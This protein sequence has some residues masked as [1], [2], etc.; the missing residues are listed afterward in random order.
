VISE[1]KEA[2]VMRS[3]LVRSALIA[4]LSATAAFGQ[5]RIIQTNSGG[6]NVHLIDPAT[7][8]VVGEIKGL[9]ANHGAIG[10]PD[11]KRLYISVEGN[12]TL[13]V[14]DAKTLQITKSIPL[15]GRPNNLAV[16]NDG[17]KVYV[18]IAA[19]P[20]A[21]EVIDTATLTSVKTIPT[22]GAEHNVYV[23]PDGKYLAAGSVGGK[24]LTV[25][26]TKTDEKVWT[27]FDQ[28]VRP[29]A[30]DTNP[31]GSTRNLYVQLSNYHGVV[32]VDFATRKEKSR[33]TMP[34]VPADQQNKGQLNSA[35]GHGL[36]VTPDNKLLVSCSRLNGHIYVYQTADLKMVADIVVGHDPDWVTFSPD[37]KFAYVAS[38][39]TDSISV[40]DLAQNKQTA[41]IPVGKAPKRNN[42]VMLKVN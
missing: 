16:T 6:E 2:Y 13:A 29:M 39:G 8:K 10:S 5:L 1:S 22:N 27:L 17:K 34:D 33:F 4:A 37:S 32:V 11:G 31:D 30:F 12:S 7:N 40:V 26:D 23:T 28:G 9:P 36:G 38:A 14:V 24:H 42:T 3:V 15:T 20:G 25:I 19:L 35:P 21:V 41:T 18:A